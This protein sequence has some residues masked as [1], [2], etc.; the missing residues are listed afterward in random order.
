MQSSA[1]A[2]LEAPTV[3]KATQSDDQALPSAPSSG[4]SSTAGA[5]FN[6]LCTVLGTGLLQLPFGVKL[7][8]WLGI[9]LL[10]L[11]GCMACYTANIMGSCFGIL[12]ARQDSL[13]SEALLEQPCAARLITY[14]DLGF[15]TFGRFGRNF[16]NVQMHVT[17]MMV[18]TIYHLLAALNVH[19]LTARAGS[20]ACEYVLGLPVSALIVAAVVWLHVFLKSLGEVAILSYI[21]ITVNCTL[22][23]VVVAATLTHQPAEAPHRELLV[24]DFLSAGG[25][26]ASFGFA[27]GCHPVLPDVLASMKKPWEYTRMIYFCFGA[28]LLL[29]LPLVTV[30]YATYGDGVESPVYE[31]AQIRDLPV[32]RVIKAVTILP[33]IFAY[34]LVLTP[35]EG[36]LERYL[37][38]DEL[39]FATLRRVGLRTLFVA[40]TTGVTVL[41]RTQENFG[42][43]LDLVSACTSTFT[44][45][46]LPCVFYVK[47]RGVGGEGGVGRAELAFNVLVVL[48][49]GVGAIFGTIQAIEKLSALGS[50]AHTN[51]TSAGHAC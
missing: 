15:A 7:F 38:I 19:W 42:P 51:S 25:A 37:R 35:P 29:Y 47:L 20:D 40:F 2:P 45:F 17:L 3:P 49:A 41:V 33:M 12:R 14:G 8:G 27:Y 6:I 4:T 48:A 43:L 31:T 50:D 1:V 36:A 46:V 28:A 18:A 26:F 34:P 39:P 21:N 9:P 11:M 5:A 30:A 32:V 44:V 10:A 16:V 24:P 23:V 22:L 13:G